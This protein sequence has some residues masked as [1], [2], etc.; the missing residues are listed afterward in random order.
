MLIA[1]DGFDSNTATG[2]LNKKWGFVQAPWQYASG[3]GK[4]GG[5]AAVAATTGGGKLARTPGILTNLTNTHGFWLKTS[6]TPAA[7]ATIE[8]VTDVNF[9]NQNAP[10]QLQTNGTLSLLGPATTTGTINVCDGN[11]HW[12]EIKRFYAP[13]SASFVI[14]VD[15]IAQ[16]STGG[17]ASG[18]PGTYDFISAAGITI[19]IDDDILY[20]DSTGVPTSANFPIGPRQ[21]STLRPTSDG[22]CT[23]STLSAGTS[24]YALVNET[25]PDGDA[26]YVQDGTSGDQD[27]LNFTSLGYT[28]ASITA[29]M[30]N[31]YVDNPSGGLINNQLV[32]KS[33]ATTAISAGANTP[34]I[35]VTRQAAFNVDP[36]TSAAWTAAGVNAAQFGYK[37]P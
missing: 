9:N 24:H 32:C 35:Y 4:F 21:I 14:Y 6:G 11:W 20:D 29:V 15:T 30:G 27:L 34:T 5:G 19:W 7:A 17:N 10:L 8:A 16:G 36:N 33:G 26:S 22:V 2:D 28:P 31:I 3:V 23:F 37:V 13:G 25:S 18:S 12:V 1:C